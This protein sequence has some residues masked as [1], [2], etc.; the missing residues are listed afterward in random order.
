MPP[1]PPTF[2]TQVQ[3]P[4]SRTNAILFPPGLPVCLCINEE[5]KTVHYQ[6]CAYKSLYINY[7]L[8]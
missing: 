4:V 3:A 5:N 6:S 7:L 8:T 2:C 1:D